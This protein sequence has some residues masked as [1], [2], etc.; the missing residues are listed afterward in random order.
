MDRGAWRAT[1][2]GI[3][4]SQTQLSTH[5]LSTGFTL[6]LTRVLELFNRWRLVRGQTRNADKDLQAVAQGSENKEQVSLPA[7]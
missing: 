4:M 2:H 1:L 3:T 6:L 7:V 5:K